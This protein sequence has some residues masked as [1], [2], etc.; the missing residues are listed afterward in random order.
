MK[1]D[2]K[3]LG[4]RIDLNLMVV[5]DAVYRSRNLGIAGQALGL[6]QP[7]MSHA[8]ARLRLL[9]KDSLFVRSPRGLQPTPYADAIAPAVAQGLGAIRSVFVTPHFDPKTSDRVFRLAMTDIGERVLLPK[10][11]AR[12]MEHAPNVGI[13]TY[14][15]SIKELRDALASGDIDFATGGVPEFDTG[16]AFRHQ[17]IVRNSY[18]CIVR[19]GHPAI[20]RTLTLKHFREARHIVVNSQMSTATVHAGNIARAMRKAIGKGKVAIRNAH[21]LAL[22]AIIMNTDLIATVPEGLAVS[23]QE[24]FKIRLFAFP[25]P[26]PTFEARLYWHER[27]D[28]EPGSRWLRQVFATLRPAV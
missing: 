14:Q 19:E 17:T 24:D 26:I 20:K 11:C 21:Y 9:V 22:P 23:F 1:S 3:A 18:V 13:E 10:L 15:P 5:F 6:S 4:H 16:S 27:Y 28:L 12:L 2:L 25:L 8:V 7:A